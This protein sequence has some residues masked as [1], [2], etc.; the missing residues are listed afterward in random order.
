[1]GQTTTHNVDDVE[2]KWRKHEIKRVVVEAKAKN[3]QFSLEKRVAFFKSLNIAKN[4]MF[5]KQISKNLKD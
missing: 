4:Q 5:Y 1:M 3:S 2:K